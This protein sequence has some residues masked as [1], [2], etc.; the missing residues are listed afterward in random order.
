MTENR[1]VWNLTTKEI[2]KKHSSRLVGGVETGSRGREDSQPGSGWRTG[3]G[4]GLQTRR[5][6]I[7]V[8]INQEEELG[9]KTDLATQGSSTG[10]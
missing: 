3:Q 10:N 2:K 6:H 8:Q 4:A 9:S 5:S 7:C 1:T